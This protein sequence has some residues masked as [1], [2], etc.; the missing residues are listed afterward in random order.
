MDLHQFIIVCRPRP[1]MAVTPSMMTVRASHWHYGTSI[2]MVPGTMPAGTVTVTRRYCDVLVKDWC[3]NFSIK[4]GFHHELKSSH[5]R[6]AASVRVGLGG[7]IYEY[8]RAEDSC[9][10]RW[11]AAGYDG[12]LAWQERLRP[13]KGKVVVESCRFII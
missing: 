7:R 2:M 11:A 8:P 9:A 10:S 6:P 1:S 4:A 3:L 5:C 12:H 13:G